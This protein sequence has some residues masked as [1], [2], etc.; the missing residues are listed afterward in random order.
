MSGELGYHL[1]D[2]KRT[3]QALALFRGPRLR[4]GSRLL[5]DAYSG[6]GVLLLRA[7]RQITGLPQLSRLLQP[8]VRFGPD[9]AFEPPLDI[10][11]EI[12]LDV[13]AARRKRP[14]PIPEERLQEAAVLKSEAVTEVTQVF[15]RIEATGEVDV[16]LAKGTVSSLVGQLLDNRDALMSLVRLKNADAYT[17]THSVNVSIL[18]MYLALGTNYERYMEELGTGALLHD[19]GKLGIPTP[20][21]NKPGPLDEFEFGLIKQHP[22]QGAQILRKSG[23]MPDI[24]LSC[25][26]DH[27][28]KMTGGGYPSGKRATDISPFAQITCLADIYDALTTDR[29]YRKAM[30]PQEAFLLMT[31]KMRDEFDPRLLYHFVSALGSFAAEEDTAPPETTAAPP[32]EPDAPQEAPGP[33]VDAAANA[34]RIDVRC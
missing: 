26:L 5:D 9:G 15:D 25:V 12:A 17:F 1:K 28:E 27:H 16:G 7:G 21:L 10:Q 29:P 22:S 13:Q 33:V 4:V 18:A 20:L 24:G 14:P 11:N 19:V 32:A 8:D 3:G 31:Q 23:Y 30:T 6:T 2:E 34:A